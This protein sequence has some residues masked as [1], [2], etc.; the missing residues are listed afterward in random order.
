M[1]LEWQKSVCEEVMALTTSQV[2]Y[3]L[4]LIFMK[5]ESCH[6][7]IYAGL[8]LAGGEVMKKIGL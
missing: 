6:K 3:L 7:E 1:G 5:V 4:R 8:V 2:F